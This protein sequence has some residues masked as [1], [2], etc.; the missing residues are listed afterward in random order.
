MNIQ[1]ESTILV[2][3]EEYRKLEMYGSCLSKW[4]TILLKLEFCPPSCI[5]RNDHIPKTGNRKMIELF[6]TV[7]KPQKSV[8]IFWTSFCDAKADIWLLMIQQADGEMSQ[9]S[10]ISLVVSSV[11]MRDS[12]EKRIKMVSIQTVIQ[13]ARIYA[14]GKADGH[15]NGQQFYRNY[16]KRVTSPMLDIKSK[17]PSV[18]LQPFRKSRQPAVCF[19]LFARIKHR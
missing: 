9:S 17:R 6:S 8:I 15:K 18:L 10:Y 1:I 11:K 14:H 7:L 19:R 13:L 5:S 3:A 4:K 2:E 12:I 16:Y